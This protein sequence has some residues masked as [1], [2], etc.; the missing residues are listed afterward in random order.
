VQRRIYAFEDK[1]RGLAVTIKMLVH[2]KLVGTNVGF[3]KGAALWL[4]LGLLAC[5]SVRHRE[6]HSD[7]CARHLSDGY[8]EMPL[9]LSS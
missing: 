3:S 5:Q 4:P 6:Q 7:A 9:S 8:G 1:Q 2:V